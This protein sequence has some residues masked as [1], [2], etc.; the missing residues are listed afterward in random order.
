MAVTFG[1]MRP[2][3]PPMMLIEDRDDNREPRLNRRHTVERAAGK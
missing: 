1:V 2:G 3:T